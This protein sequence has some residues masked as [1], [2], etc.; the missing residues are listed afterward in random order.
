MNNDGSIGTKVDTTP[1]NTCRDKNHY[2]NLL[3]HTYCLACGSKIE[4]KKPTDWDAYEAEIENH[5]CKL[6]SDGHCPCTPNHD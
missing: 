6:E 3:L 5:D 2:S 1:V 4:D